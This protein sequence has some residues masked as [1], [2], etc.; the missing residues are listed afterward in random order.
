MDPGVLI[1]AVAIVLGIGIVL[2][3]V[4]LQRSATVRQAK[5]LQTVDESIRNQKESMGLQREQIELLKE[6]LKT[7]Q[8]KG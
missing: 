2:Y 5:A 4:S 7:L 1:G 6:I 8:A 3:S